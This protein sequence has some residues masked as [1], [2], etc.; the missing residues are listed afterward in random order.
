MSRI[1]FVPAVLALHF[2]HLA[3]AEEVNVGDIAL[4]LAGPSSYPESAIDRPG[5]LPHAGFLLNLDG[6]SARGGRQGAL[7]LALG[8]WN[9]LEITLATRQSLSASGS[10]ASLDGG[11]GLLVLLRG[12]VEIDARFTVPLFLS[13]TTFHGFDLG[14]V[15]SYTLQ[16][17]LVL[18]AYPQL[19]ID[20]TEPESQWS[21]PLDLSLG[22]QATEKCFL[23]LGTLA[24]AYNGDA[25]EARTLV[26]KAPVTLDVLYSLNASWDLGLALATEDAS[27][28]SN[29]WIVSLSLT[30]K[31]VR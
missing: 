27:R 2:H 25:D 7:S 23:S 4:P 21:I 17:G 6:E 22:I 15:T 29:R 3:C 11:L 5:I 20:V 14:V 13:G 1:A 12:P 16:A 9:R 26:E 19:H 8:L 10:L 18:G 31:A 28:A 30:W 24:F